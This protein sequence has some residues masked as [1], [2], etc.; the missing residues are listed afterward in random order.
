MAEQ[1]KELKMKRGQAKAWVTRTK[2]YVDKLSQTDIDE[3][4]LK[5][6][7]EE[8]LIRKLASKIDCLLIALAPSAHL[9]SPHA[10]SPTQSQLSAKSNGHIRLPQIELP[11]FSGLYEEWYSFRDTFKSLIHENSWLSQIQKFHYLCSSLKGEAADKTLSLE[12]L[13]VNYEEA[14]KSLQTLEAITK[15]PTPHVTNHNRQKLRQALSSQVTANTF[16]VQQK[17]RSYALIAC[18]RQITMPS[19]AMR[20][21]VKYATE[22]IT[23]CYKPGRSSR[24]VLLPSP[25]NAT[26]QVA[27]RW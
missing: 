11:Q 19:S 3:Q 9:T 27:K 17:Q 13:E 5:I 24:R 8:V 1:L 14:R 21:G 25:T 16:A 6:D 18:G 22:S 20:V 12:I 4:Q 7:R 15:T 10:P 2:A 26:S 23:P